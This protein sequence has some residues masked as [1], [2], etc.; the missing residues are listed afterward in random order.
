MRVHQILIGSHNPGK[1]LEYETLLEPLGFYVLLPQ[2]C[3]IHE[4]P[5]ED[6]ETFE[7]NAIAKARYY[8]A[9]VNIPLIAEDSGLCVD[10]LDGK[11]GV[12]SRRWLG[13]ESSDEELL[14]TLLSRLEGV[15]FAK[16]A[17]SLRVVM[18]FQYS[19][20][21]PRD[22]YAV[23]EGV[24]NGFITESQEVEIVPGYPFRSVFYVP[25]LEKVL[26]ALSME[27]EA[28]VAHRKK[29]LDQLI[30]FINKVFSYT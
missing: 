19:R 13:V 17:A 3:G 5:P 30:P 6:E 4:S 2:D 25:E 21:N 14:E 10:A 18:V 22:T 15:P 27:E 24:L 29:A 20:D 12:H 9:R 7:G 23:S 26:G 16:R 28:Q 11:P 1:I 8:G